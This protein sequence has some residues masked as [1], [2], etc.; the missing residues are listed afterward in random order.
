MARRVTLEKLL[1]DFRAE[2]RMSLNPAHN[3]QD[4]LPQIKLL[5]RTQ[6]RLWEDFDWPHLIVERQIA[7]QAGQ[8]YYDT[9]P[10][11]RVDRVLKISIFTDGAWRELCPG[12]GDE[13]YSAWNSDLDERNWP[14]RRWKIHEDEDIELW[15]IADVNAD[16]DTREGYLKFIG[17]RNL[18]PLVADSD[19]CDLDAQ[20]LVLYAAAERLAATGGKDA[21]LKL[22]QANA[23]YARLRGN[24][25]PATRTKMFVPDLGARPRRPVIT[26]YRPPES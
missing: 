20:L 22:E 9:P 17:V 8:R 14:P 25:T 10:D 24:L 26:Q 6:E 19:R 13:Q 23:R 11:I 3:A 12:I 5:Q 1:D 2:A 15:P 18:N 16:D 7:V 21:P 4:R